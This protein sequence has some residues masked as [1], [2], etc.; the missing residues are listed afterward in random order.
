[1]SIYL[2]EYSSSKLS[3][4]I[5]NERLDSQCK[6]NIV[7][8]HHEYIYTMKSISGKMCDTIYI[9]VIAERKKCI[10]QKKTQKHIFSYLFL[11]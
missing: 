4:L 2:K 11:H 3:V 9:I 6:L 7:E 1:M 5:V 8:C 10:R